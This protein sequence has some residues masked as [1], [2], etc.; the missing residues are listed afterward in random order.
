MLAR[1]AQNVVRKRRLQ[2]MPVPRA[3]ARPAGGYVYSIQELHTLIP[4]DSLARRVEDKC[5]MRELR[6]TRESIRKTLAARSWNPP[7]ELLRAANQF[8]ARRDGRLR[9][10]G[11]RR[12]LHHRGDRKSLRC[13]P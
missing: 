2:R 11:S 5:G 9:Q 8:R 12:A 6:S 1:H 3:N 7:A 10:T 4:R 13:R